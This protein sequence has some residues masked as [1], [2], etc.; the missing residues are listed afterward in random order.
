[1]YH[2]HNRI[3]TIVQVNFVWKDLTASVPTVTLPPINNLSIA[4]KCGKIHLCIF[5]NCVVLM[6]KCLQLLVF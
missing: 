6:I 3:V 5:F 4:L 2:C 1:M